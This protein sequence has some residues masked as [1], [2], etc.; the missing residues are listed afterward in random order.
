MSVVAVYV[1]RKQDGYT[2]AHWE[3]TWFAPSES[4]H[5]A[6]RVASYLDPRNV[7]EPATSK[8][9]KLIEEQVSADY[10]LEHLSSAGAGISAW[11]S[12]GY[13]QL[14]GR[15]LAGSYPTHWSAPFELA[16]SENLGLSGIDSET[17]SAIVTALRVCVLW[18]RADDLQ[19]SLRA[20]DALHRAAEL[21]RRYDRMFRTDITA[22]DETEGRSAADDELSTAELAQRCRLNLM[23]H[24]CMMGIDMADIEKW[25]QTAPLCREYDSKAMNNW[26]NLWERKEQLREKALAA[27]VVAASDILEKEA[28]VAKSEDIDKNE[29]KDQG[30]RDEKGL[31]KKHTKGKRRKE[32]K[33]DA[34]SKLAQEATPATEP[35]PL[36]SLIFTRVP[37]ASPAFMRRT[38]RALVET[39]FGASD[40]NE[41]DWLEDFSFAK[42]LDVPAVEATIED[43]LAMLDAKLAE[44]QASAE[45]A[46]ATKRVNLWFVDDDFLD[47]NPELAAELFERAP[48]FDGQRLLQ[49]VYDEEL[50]ERAYSYFK[51]VF[52]LLERGHF[53]DALAVLQDN[54]MAGM[55]RQVTRSRER[56]SEMKTERSEAPPNSDANATSTTAER[57]AMLL[58]SAT[59]SELDDLQIAETGMRSMLVSEQASCSTDRVYR[60]S[61]IGG[62]S[63]R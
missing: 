36:R 1:Q 17:G 3:Q 24:Y 61:S 60:K 63:R 48:Y 21:V 18:E 9:E 15:R 59:R 25:V 30:R 33:R 53:K 42:E 56:S 22:D 12:G 13:Y 52:Y 32:R 23:L 19:A 47:Q 35:D 44:E 54:I 7:H 51:A 49:R 8:L 28:N 41:D 45:A 57:K 40:S 11:S 20:Y 55:V 4:K 50:C 2:I 46:S 38:R 43:W 16:V 5:W 29:P 10:G 31:K 39:L 14:S 37:F 27:G 62:G 34:L 6:W 26:R 58:A